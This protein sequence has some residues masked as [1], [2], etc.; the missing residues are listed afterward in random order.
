LSPALA[1]EF[2]ARYGIPI[3]QGYGATEF[4]GGVSGWADGLFER[5]GADKHGSVGRPLPGIRLRVVDEE[6]GAEVAVGIVGT[7]EV[8]SPNRVK[9]LPPGWVR[10]SDLARIDEDGFLWIV[11]RRDDVVIRGGFKVDLAEVEL[12]LEG[13]PAVAQ[14]CAVGLPDDR[15]GTVP[16]AVVVL[17]PDQDRDLAG[18]DLVAWARERLSGYAVPASVL[19]VDELPLN[20]MMK[21][22][23]NGARDLVLASVAEPERS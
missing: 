17:R 11:G 21:K 14:A 4:L 9:D 2:E 19:V 6:T 22:D 13:H 23:R 10:T 3:V 16:H 7:L 20:A 1:A 18:G 12:T 15:L 5:F 8:D